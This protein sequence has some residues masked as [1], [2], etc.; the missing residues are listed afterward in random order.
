MSDAIPEA[1]L[2][3]HI[4]SARTVVG[5]ERFDASAP[6]Q[7]LRPGS[8]AMLNAADATT[9]KAVDPDSGTVPR[10]NSVTPP[11]I[12]AP[13]R[14][15]A[16]ETNVRTA[17][18]LDGFARS[19]EYT[20]TGR[21]GKGGMGEIFLAEQLG[22]RRD[23][24]IKRIIPEHL[25]KSSAQ[26]MTDAFVAEALVT[27]YLDHPNIV[28]VHALGR[29]DAGNWFFSMKMVRGIEWRLLL[30]PDRC[31][32][33]ESKEKSLARKL[34]VDNPARRAAHLEENLR[35][36]L[37]VCNAVAFAHSKYII[38]RDLKPENVMVGAFGEVLTMDWG[39]AADVSDEP[40]PPGHPHRRV[41][42][43]GETGIGGTPSY[44]APEQFHFDENGQ[45]S[46]ARLGLWT[47]VFLLGAMLYEILSGHAPYTGSSVS[48]ALAKVAACDPS[49]LPES[50][51]PEL[52]A[53][54]RKAL[55][56]N[57][58]DRYPD[59]LAFQKAVQE[60]LTHRQAAAIAAKAEHEARTPEIPN[61]ARAVVLYDQALELWP[62]NAAMAGSAK[63]ALTSLA[64]K[65]SR[66]R[67]MRRSLY[68]AVASIVIGLTLGFVWIRAEQQKAVAEKLRAD[69]NEKRALA[70]RND[71]QNALKEQRRLSFEASYLNA[72]TFE[73]NDSLEGIVK[74]LAPYL[75]V[76]ELK[77]HLSYATADQMNLRALQFIKLNHDARAK[78]EAREAAVQLHVGRGAILDLV[79]IP[80]GKFMMGNPEDGLYRGQKKQH[81]ETIEQPF[82]MGKYAVTQAQYEAVADHNPSRFIGPMNPVETVSWD[83]ANAFCEKLNTKFKGTLPESFSIQLPTEA[84]WEYACRAGTTSEFNTGDVLT[85]EQA[86]YDWSTSYHGSPTKEPLRKTM[87]VDSFQAN[88]F[89]LFCMHGNVHQW[90]RDEYARDT[91]N[92]G[93]SGVGRV[94]T[95]GGN[96]GGKTETAMVPG[97]DVEIPY[98]AQGVGHVMRGSSWESHAMRCRSADRITYSPMKYYSVGFRVVVAPVTKANP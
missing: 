13:G 14:D 55:S 65:E 60:F 76:P 5:A 91:S 18:P 6:D 31:K 27:G 68:G 46:G 61:L 53:I 28:P 11:T 3:S 86:N 67:W 85:P 7:T 88:A 64:L 22:L 93:V 80:A 73:R 62:E 25:E 8:T 43:R 42:P 29:D 2:K 70:A 63:I 15:E 96:G 74:T 95:D 72:Q 12:L 87:P 57:P 9:L 98:N 17:S 36:L 77:A 94:K 52:A 79:L 38:H 41:P 30:H 4:Q 21:V 51:P 40:P 48:D 83:E 1:L 44:M 84:A 78:M 97:D 16:C 32:D 45:P 66:A 10:G 20:L 47:D 34:D 54:C 26:K 24:A 37:S 50:T 82:Y 89:G 90:C 33:A 71:A 49:P 56:K 39:L 69:E 59:A 92:V 58:H 23:V 35:I 19:S 81:A 75:S